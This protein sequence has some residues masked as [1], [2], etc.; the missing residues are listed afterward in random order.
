MAD[1]QF[2]PGQTN[3]PKQDWWVFGGNAEEVIHDPS[4]FGPLEKL[5]E[6]D[7]KEENSSFELDLNKWTNVAESVENKKIANDSFDGYAIPQ[8][9]TTQETIDK[10]KEKSEQISFDVNLNSEKENS[11][12]ETKDDKENKNKE[13]KPFAETT[14]A[15][16]EDEKSVIEE[17]PI[18]EETPI[19]EE[20]VSETEEEKPLLEETPIVEETP[21]IEEAPAEVELESKKISDIQ[22]KFNNLLDNISQLNDILKIKNWEVLEIVWANSDKNNILYQF[23]LNDQKEVHVKRIETDKGNNETIFNEL[24]L[25][26]NPESN[27]FEIFLDD[28]LLF[29]ESDLLDDNKKKSQVME[30]VNKLIF[31]TESK[32]KDAQKE[33]KAKKEEEEERKRLQDIFRNF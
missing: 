3:P 23:W 8:D 7:K 31:L 16:V 18:V 10:S 4:M 11:V 17:T 26:L 13:E 1:Q 33:L 6:N 15:V 27:L 22:E 20:T 9:A 24:K 2:Q 21:A 19:T 5:E 12:L 28:V 29:E 14:P 25:G 30:K 32:L